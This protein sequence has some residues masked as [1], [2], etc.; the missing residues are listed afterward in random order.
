[1]QAGEF[2][3]VDIDD[4]THEE[5]VALGHRMGDV[6]Q[7]Q[8]K[9]QA[10]EAVDKLPT[11]RYKKDSKQEDVHLCT[12]CQCEFEQDDV[13]KVLPCKHRFH[14]GCIGDWLKKNPECPLC[15]RS[16][17]DNTDGSQETTENTPDSESPSAESDA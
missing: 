14:N 3:D 15:K 7:E 1:M 5:L 10:Q 8:W 4:M 6:K 17:M 16:I 9:R 12:V 11:K 13:I 2:D